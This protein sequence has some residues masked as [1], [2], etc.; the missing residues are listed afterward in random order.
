MARDPHPS[1]AG[2]PVWAQPREIVVMRDH[3]VAYR[4]AWALAVM[5]CARSAGAE[6]PWPEERLQAAVRAIVEEAG[7]RGKGARVR[8][9]KL[10]PRAATLVLELPPTVDLANLPTDIENRY[11][12]VVGAL[13][14]ARPEIRRIDLAVAHPG[15]V[16]RPPPRAPR[17]R[18]EPP[19]P[20]LRSV[21]TDPARFPHGQ[22]LRGRTIAISPGHGYIYY[23]SLGRYATQ[24]G[25]IRWNDCGD[26]RG[27]IEDFETHEVVVDHLVP[28]LEGAG[29]RVV[30][31]RDR[32][33]SSVGVI[34]DDGDGD[35]R[36][37]GAGFIDGTSAG[38]H[39]GDYRAT[40]DR[41]AS[42]EWTVAAPESGPQLLSTWFVAGANRRLAAEL[43]VDL[44]GHV[45]RYAIDLRSHGRRWAPIGVF[46]LDAATTVTVR[47][48]HGTKGPDGRFI[49]A[50]AV[51]LGA[52][53]H[54]TGH[55]W[56]QMGAKP[57]AQYQSAPS[58]V[59]SRGDV[60]I[61][62]RYAEF[63]GA[64]VYLSV[65][66]NASGQPNSTAAGTST[67]RYSCGRFD[68]HTSDPPAADCDDPLGSDR[69]QQLVHDGMVNRLRAEWDPNWRD[70]GT[71][72]A[73]F[74][75]VR[76]LD[77]IPGALVE[78]AFHDNV[79]LPDG[80][81]LKMTDNQSLHDPR[82]RD[83]V[84]YGMYEGLSEFLVGAG[85]LLA[86]PPEAVLARRI[87]ATSVEVTFV[88]VP[89]AMSYR[90]YT[91][92][93]RRVFDQGSIARGTAIAVDGLDPEVPAFFKV[94]SLHAAGE[95]LSSAIVTARPSARRA[96][97]LIVDAFQRRD[98]WTSVQDNRHDTSMTHGL[99]LAGTAAAFDGT[100]EAGLVAGIAAL[101]GYDAVVLALGRESTEHDVLTEDLRGQVAS[102]AA[103]GGAVFAGGS[104]IAWALDARGDDNTRGFLE[105]V[106]GVA[107]DRDD[108]GAAA[109]HV[110]PGGWLAGAA[111]PNPM[112]LDDGTAGGLPVRSSDVLRPLAGSE[113]EL[114]YDG[115]ND[116]A[117]VRRGVNLVLGVALD[118]IAGNGERR[119]VL[120]AWVDNAITL[121]PLPSPDAGVSIDAGQI[122]AA[123]RDAGIA[124]AADAGVP[125]APDAT[126]PF[127]AGPPATWPGTP[128]RPPIDGGCGCSTSPRHGP[129][130]PLS[131]LVALTLLW[132]KMRRSLRGL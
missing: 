26:C 52:G 11:E 106:F 15:E 50:D 87:D 113:I 84:A 4:L 128:G 118:T 7:P 46:D 25:L 72:V 103:S 58:G 79:R 104:E 31:V 132:T 39:G 20:A 75:E 131:W 49:V 45:L 16:A 129:T 82:W 119:A 54:S 30:L 56:W 18:L 27:V 42:V 93:G 91:A 83:I 21:T 124:D 74:G 2:L 41:S 102:F 111:V 44:A 89:E 101:A 10:D 92:Q 59:L 60:T 90:V 99:A 61:R 94:S 105:A 96:Q 6:L 67:Y 1:V 3:R 17:D 108:A 78:S 40:D 114:V 122:D 71:R 123:P 35:Y 34:V 33:R 109:L 86:P 23:D 80:S 88:A 126:R 100:T 53:V 98:A 112:T 64:D 24:R 14:A 32:S 95:G 130:W 85:P 66:S 12:L 97:I 48:R 51:R 47:L 37:T 43:E 28:L 36:E 22:A 62:P 120:G 127:D 55:P 76:E 8:R 73:N 13:T 125:A 5:L 65:H 110:A 81:N 19:P 70:R 117:A 57:F 69:L 77:G 115:G 121:A 38:G 116:V 107:Y 63:Y 9:L 29:A 68:N